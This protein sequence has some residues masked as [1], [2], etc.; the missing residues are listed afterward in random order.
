MGTGY[1]RVFVLLAATGLLVFSTALAGPRVELKSDP[2]GDLVEIWI[3]GEH[4]TSYR[5]GE[6]FTRKPVFYPVMSPD[7]VMVN[8]E[9]P[10][11]RQ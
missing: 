11:V 1:F 8:Q 5:Y 6:E 4:F 3:D 10:Q 9:L 7:G 2:S